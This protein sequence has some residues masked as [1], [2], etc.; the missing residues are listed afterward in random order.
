MKKQALTGETAAFEPVRGASTNVPQTPV[1]PFPRSGPGSA[2]LSERCAAAAAKMRRPIPVMIRSEVVTALCVDLPHAT[3]RQRRA[4]L[5]YAVE[6]RLAAP[7]ET[8]VVLPGPLQGAP[9]SSVLAL[10]IDRAAL[11][12]AEATAPK[13]AAIL[14]DFLA[15]PRPLAGASGPSWAVWRDGARCVV[16]VSDGTGFAVATEML[17]LVWRRAGQPP[18]TSFGAALP[19]GLP[20]NDQSQTPPP[21]DHADLAFSFSNHARGDG[22]QDLRRR[23]LMAG[24]VLALGL[25]LQLGLAGADA[26]ALSQ[27]VKD[28]RR[29]AETALA[30]VLPDVVISDDLDPILTRL[31]PNV[32]RIERGDLLPLLSEVSETLIVADEATSFRRM[33]WSKADEELVVQVQASSLED[34]QRVQRTLQA[35]GFAVTSGAANAGDGMAEVEMRISRGAAR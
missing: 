17:A 34:L 21:P 23:S 15:I 11:A 19:L 3:A 1:T 16:R 10:A 18:L 26:I 30:Q 2:P 9:K 32:V 7:I 4:M 29:A 6:E 28:E 13:G 14:P 31:A 25:A 5:T 12:I 27:I 8:L 20:A 35:G 33:S 22:A 24:G